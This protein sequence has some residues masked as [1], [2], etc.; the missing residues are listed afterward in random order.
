MHKSYRTLLLI[1]ALGVM[2]PSAGNAAV[3][4]FDTYEPDL[5]VLESLVSELPV[6]DPLAEVTD[7]LQT[8][9]DQGINP[10]GNL[11]V[12]FENDSVAEPLSLSL[13]VM[14]LAGLGAR[15]WRERVSV[16]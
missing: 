12:G 16:D 3:I 4:T 14:G 2:V 1:V 15:R 7:S 9:V 11:I 6:Q 13:L 10:G 8:P 5:S